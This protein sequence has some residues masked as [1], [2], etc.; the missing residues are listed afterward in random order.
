MA[1]PPSVQAAF[2][3]LTKEQQRAFKQEYQRRVK[4]T[5]IA[6]LAWLLLGWHYL[7]VGRVGMQ[8]AFW[9]TF[10]FLIVGWFI[11]FF[12]VPGMVRR[13]NDDLARSL[14]SQHKM[15]TG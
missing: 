7:Y 3:T 14:M 13:H 11:D 6:Y 1:L 12:R 9:F 8:F 2:S 10:G 4:S 15:M 5:L